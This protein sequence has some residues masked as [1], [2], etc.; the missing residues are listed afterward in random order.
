[1]SFV[2]FRAPLQLQGRWVEVVFAPLLLFTTVAQYCIRRNA[3]CN[4]VCGPCYNPWFAAL[5]TLL[6]PCCIFWPG[7][8]LVWRPS[9]ADTSLRPRLALVCD[10]FICLLDLFS[11]TVAPWLRLF[12]PVCLAC[13]AIVAP[14]CLCLL[15]LFATL[16]YEYV[17]ISCL[18]PCL[19]LDLF[20]PR[21]PWL[22][23]HR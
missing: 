7:C 5:F 3:C 18:L 10:L 1:V 21:L 22:A 4:P 6:H 13:L 14:V 16:I 15:T 12:A 9:F 8:A 19:P 23:H 11:V 20:A 2:R 17:A